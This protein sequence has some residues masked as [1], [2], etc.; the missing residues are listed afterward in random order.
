MNLK[1]TMLWRYAVKKFDE[2][3]KVSEEK[4]NEILEITNL[5]PTSYGLQPY[6]TVICSNQDIKNKLVPA[7]YRQ[8][9]IAESSHLIVFAARTDINEKYINKFIKLT[10]DIRKIN[11]EE[12][13]E[14]K[15]ML[16]N[17][18]SKKTDEEI[19]NWASKQAYLALGTFLTACAN[20]KIDSC[21]IG[22]FIPEK[23][24]EIL[25]LQ[26]YNLKSV[27]AAVVGYRH[28]DDKYQTL[29]KVR[30]PNNE[31]IINIK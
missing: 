25:N 14:F 30:K 29:A 5:A 7:S 23:Y 2:T 21:P 24:D 28:P 3:K 13:E 1:E 31:M 4:L 26:K 11:V 27:V 8:K 6:M 15:N 18:F 17:S 10:A 22:G 19:F 9:S 16:I 20:E 12:L